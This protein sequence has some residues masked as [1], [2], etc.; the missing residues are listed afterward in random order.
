[1]MS[2]NSGHIPENSL[3]DPRDLRNALGRFLTGVCIIT[4]RDQATGRK[5]GLTANSFASV[6][7]N[8]PLVLWSLSNSSTSA[9]VFNDHDFFAINVLAKGQE[10]ISNHFAKSNPEK[11]L[12]FSES[13]ID[14][15]HGVP[16]VK[17]AVA[18]FECRTVHRYS[19]GDHVIVVGLVE[20]YTHSDLEPLALLRGN[21]VALEQN[22]S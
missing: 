5:V 4:S 18:T 16:V 8:P 17:G 21:Y 13:F 19:G 3:F 14:G 9:E 22:A 6:S 1:M 15:H 20:R 12:A 2:D 11:F 10:P 7:L